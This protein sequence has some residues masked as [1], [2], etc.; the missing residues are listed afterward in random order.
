M[1]LTPYESGYLDGY[2]ERADRAWALWP[3]RYDPE[4]LAKRLAYGRGWRDGWREAGKK[5]ATA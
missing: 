2:A 5:E 3:K 4:H 1:N